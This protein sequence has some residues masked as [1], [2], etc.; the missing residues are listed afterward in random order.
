MCQPPPGGAA[1][2]VA[3]AE[4]PSGAAQA[5]TESPPPLPSRLAAPAPQPQ[6]VAAVQPQV[7]LQ[8]RHGVPQDLAAAAVLR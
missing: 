6:D 8:Q 3:A 5:G 1:T 7:S 2:Q 4:V